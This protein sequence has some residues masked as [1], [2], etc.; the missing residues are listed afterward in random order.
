MSSTKS[1]PAWEYCRSISNNKNGTICTF[2]GHT[3]QSGEIIRFKFHLIG[4]ELYKK[5]K[6][7][8][9]CAIGN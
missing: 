2:C 1:D 7:M 9:K 8:L 5:C 4:N 6:S 3:M